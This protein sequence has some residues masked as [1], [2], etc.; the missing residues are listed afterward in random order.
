MAYQGRVA[1]FEI[2]RGTLIWSRDLSSL[3]GLAADS[4]YLYVTDDSGAVHALDKTTGASV[5]K[6]DKLA[7]RS[8]GGPQLVGEFLVVVDVEGYAHLLD[9]NDGNLVA[10][11]ATDGSPATAQP[12]RSGGN[13]VWLST[14]GA[15]VSVTAR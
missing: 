11:I 6:Q 4:R 15:L 3:Y 12:A 1:C 13:A 9:R 7:Q 2:L 14:S 10:R 8:P 5:W